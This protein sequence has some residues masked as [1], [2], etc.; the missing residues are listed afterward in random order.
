[1]AELGAKPPTRSERIRTALEEDIVAGRLRPGDRLDE[2]SLAHRFNVS[3]TPI[4]EALH[5][6]SASG[7]I[8]VRPRRGAVIRQHTMRDLLEILEVLAELESLCVRMAVRRMGEEERATL[9]E[10]HETCLRAIESDCDDDTYYEANR[11]FHDLLRAGAR[12]RVLQEAAQGLYIRATPYGRHHLRTPD[13][14]RLSAQ[15]HERIVKAVLA[16]DEDAAAEAMR[17]H[18]SVQADL[19]AEFFFSEGAP[20]PS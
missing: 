7:F 20:Q 14:R 15:D 12:N 17:L 6:L 4:R 1:M 9:A 13:R 2:H 11:R 16:G 5:Q 3:R 18:I 8:E 10:V 19:F